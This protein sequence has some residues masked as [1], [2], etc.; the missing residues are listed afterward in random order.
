MVLIAA[1]SVSLCGLSLR[2]ASMSTSS[3]TWYGFGTGPRFF[4]V[5]DGSFFYFWTNSIRIPSGSTAQTTPAGP[6]IDPATLRSV[7][8]C[9]AWPK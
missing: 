7:R 8:R 5:P 3:S 9:E 6:I 2:T 1:Y 4:T